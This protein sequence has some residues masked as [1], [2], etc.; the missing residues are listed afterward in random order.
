MRECACMCTC[1]CVRARVCTRVCARECAHE[2]VCESCACECVC[3]HMC[4]IVRGPGPV[5]THSSRT[6]NIPV[7]T[8]ALKSP[9]WTLARGLVPAS[10]AD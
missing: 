7:L 8:E 3:V 5:L 1:E 4:R 10:V 6:R 9:S 2:C